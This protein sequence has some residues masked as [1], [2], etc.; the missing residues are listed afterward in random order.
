VYLPPDLAK[1]LAY[2]CLDH[3]MTFSEA[4]VE[5]LTSLLAGG[6]KK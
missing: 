2:Y 4:A 5:A 6:G 1:R 3:E